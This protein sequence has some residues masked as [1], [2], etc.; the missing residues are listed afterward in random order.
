MTTEPKLFILTA[1]QG[2]GLLYIPESQ[3]AA[4]GTTSKCRG[5]KAIIFTTGDKEFEVIEPVEVIIAE[6]SKTHN[7][8]DLTGK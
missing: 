7:V 2:G 4:V 5:D 3:I 1:A 6:M 8:K